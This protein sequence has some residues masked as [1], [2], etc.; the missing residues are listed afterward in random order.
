MDGTDML[1]FGKRVGLRNSGSDSGLP[2]FA[3]TKVGRRSRSGEDGD[4]RD[5]GI[6]LNRPR[7]GAVAFAK[8]VFAVSLFRHF[9]A[10]E[11][12][13]GNH[14]DGPWK[15]G[16]PFSD[17]LRPHFAWHWKRRYRDCNPPI[18][19]PGTGLLLGMGLVALACG[20]RRC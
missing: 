10:W 11:E 20:R 19:E 4:R 5:F 3:E 2:S 9:D 8:N 14:Q 16:P 7:E 1:A 12:H 15:V 17:L 6:T 18:P 13:P